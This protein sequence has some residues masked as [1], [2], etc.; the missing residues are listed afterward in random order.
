MLLIGLDTVSIEN[1]ESTANRQRSNSTAEVP[2]VSHHG[3]MT[4]PKGDADQIDGLHHHAPTQAHSTS[5]AVEEIYDPFSP[6]FSPFDPPAPG[7]EANFPYS[8]P[9]HNTSAPTL[10]LATAKPVTARSLTVP[11]RKRLIWAPECAVYSTY[12]PGT[13]D[14]R[15][16]LATCNRLTPELALAIKQEWVAAGSIMRGCADAMAAGSTL[17]NSRCLCIPLLAY[18]PTT[19]PDCESRRQLRGVRWTVLTSGRGADGVCISIYLAVLA[20]SGCIFRSL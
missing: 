5:H 11:A 19:L 17:S 2:Q 18:T 14:R 10:S 13:Y 12:D 15:S 9:S 20:V 8:N 7:S 3:P 4:M 1:L 16:E 6:A